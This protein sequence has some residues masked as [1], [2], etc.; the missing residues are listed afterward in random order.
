MPTSNK[1]SI[2]PPTKLSPLT[3]S[4]NIAKDNKVGD[5]GINVMKSIFMITSKKF[6]RA[7]Y[8]NFKGIVNARNVAVNTRIFWYLSLDT[9]RAFNFLQHAFTK[10]HILQHF[11]L[12]CYIWFQTDTL[13]YA[14]SGVVNELILNY[15]GQWHSVAYYS[16]K[17][18]LAKTQ[19]KTH[20]G[21]L[22]VIVKAFKTWRHYQKDCKDKV[23]VLTNHNNLWCFMDTKNLSSRQVC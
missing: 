6:F 10:A 12:K 3:P 17:I 22:L 4:I 1:S 23:H 20:K 7:D 16:E 11:N 15:L 2:L 21:E 19:Y 18:I 9:K 14:I 13:G 5:D 8:L